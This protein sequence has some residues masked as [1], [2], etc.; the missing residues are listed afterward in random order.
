[1]C[2]WKFCKSIFALL[3]AGISLQPPLANA[4]ASGSNDLPLLIVLVR[5]ADKASQPADDP[6][7]TAA[8]TQRAQDL[9]VSL[10]NTKFTAI[11]TTQFLRVRNTAEPLAAALGL[12]PE[13]L[14]IKDVNS[15]ADQ[16]AHIKALIAALH[17][18]AAGSVL[19]VEHG[20]MISE[21]IAALGGP[22]LPVVC[23][24]VFDH[25]FVIVPSTGKI[26]LINSRY[27]AP[28]PPAGPDCM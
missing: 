10:R 13:I 21:I 26:Q 4:E 9:A 14:A 3:L 23:D 5:H 2:Q 6:P 7:L 20:N 17:K 28:S 27:G 12:T 24:P 25:L 15:P 16:D 11:I 18:N 22:R 19:V 1:M 8:G